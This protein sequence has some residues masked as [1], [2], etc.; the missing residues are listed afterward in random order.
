MLQSNVVMILRD[1]L[2]L[3]TI[4]ITVAT[5]VILTTTTTDILVA[6]DIMVILTLA[7]TTDL[8]TVTTMAPTPIRIPTTRCRPM[9]LMNSRFPNVLRLSSLPATLLKSP[10]TT[11]TATIMVSIE[12]VVVV[13]D[14]E[15]SELKTK[16]RSLVK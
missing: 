10:T 12:E 8:I 16:I 9:F 7:P 15:C 2:G 11:F 14:G 4:T 1:P 3:V 13:M 6:M 5:T